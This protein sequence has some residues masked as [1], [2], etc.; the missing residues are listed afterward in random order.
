MNSCNKKIQANEPFD[1]AIIGTGLAGLMLAVALLENKPTAQ[2]KIL[3][4]DSSFD[5]YA[6]RTWCF[7]QAG[8]SKWDHLAEKS[9]TNVAF[10]LGDKTLKKN[11]LPYSYN[12]IS[13]NRFREY[14]WS[15]IRKHGHVHAE[16]ASV[17]SITTIGNEQVIKT[18][19]STFR[20]HSVFDSRFEPQA[21]QH[22]AGHTLYQ[23]FVG[24]FVQAKQAIFDPST[25][26]LMDF[27]V[28]QS[29]AVAFCYL[30]PTS[31]HTALVEYTLFTPSILPEHQLE[32]ALER[33]IQEKFPEA[34]MTAIA[35]EK[36]IIPMTD[37]Q[38]T[39]PHRG[40]VPIGTAGGC[41]K[42]STGYTFSFVCRHTEKIIQDINAGKMPRAYK[43]EVPTRF[44][45][46][47]RIMLAI[48]EKYP[49]KGAGLL[50][51][52]FQ[53]NKVQDVL[54]FLDN[55]STIGTELSIFKSLPIGLF[56]KQAIQEL[57]KSPCK[58]S[59]RNVDR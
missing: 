52:L 33:Y 48:M 12:L 43:E 50:F 34:E 7:W 53:N 22:R 29:Q 49:E 13:S 16:E 24:H 4:L 11:L 9:W 55:Q 39:Q 44:D 40:I 37:Y 27:T 41:S 1:F 17:C 26:L 45:F 23:Q 35:R 14:A 28:P 58:L 6:P 25:A 57:L 2:K 20:A 59:K 10:A 8:T 54:R 15:I 42:P 19:D 5:G 31:A 47:D 30:L 46:Y 18:A 38:F 32:Q 51:R 56:S 21:L 36:G 3:L